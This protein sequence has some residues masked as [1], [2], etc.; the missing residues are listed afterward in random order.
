MIVVSLPELKQVAV[1]TGAEAVEEGEVVDAVEDAIAESVMVPGA[2][3]VKTAGEE[4]RLG[5]ALISSVHNY[6]LS[7]VM[8][9][10]VLTL[11]RQS[12]V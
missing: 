10:T 12:Q 5:F 7:A 3:G 9:K 11:S 2:R 8:K 4:A 1:G 6:A